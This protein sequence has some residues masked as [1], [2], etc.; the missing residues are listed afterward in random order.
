MEDIWNNP[1]N[2]LEAPYNVTGFVS[3]C[4]DDC[5]QNYLIDNGTTENSFMWYVALARITIIETVSRCGC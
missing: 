1:E 3:H 4:Y 2:Y 5:T